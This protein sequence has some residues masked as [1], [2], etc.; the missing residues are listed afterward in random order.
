MSG[1]FV[2]WWLVTLF[3]SVYRRL[4]ALLISIH[5]MEVALLI[6][7]LG[8]SDASICHRYETLSMCAYKRYVTSDAFIH[9]WYVPLLLSTHCVSGVVHICLPYM[10]SATHVCSFNSN[11]LTYWWLY[12]CTS[13]YRRKVTLFLYA[14]RM[15]AV[16]LTTAYVIYLITKTCLYKVDPI[17]PHFYIVKLGFTGDTLFFLF[18]LKNIDC[19]Y[20]LEPPHRGGSKQYP[21]SMFWA[22]MW[23]ISELLSENFHFFGGIFSI[24]LNRLV[25]VMWSSVYRRLVELK[26]RRYSCLVM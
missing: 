15:W 8:F 23:K 17:K 25:F 24:Y 11:A 22:E 7:V 10:S 3:M 20:S 14:H 21:Q 18:L 19:G 4:E 16:L 13:V 6:S 26:V 9:C 5:Q 1:T 2:C 12:H